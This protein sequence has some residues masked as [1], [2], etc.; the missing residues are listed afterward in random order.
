MKPKVEKPY[1]VKPKEFY[2]E[3]VI[4]K[5][6]DALTPRAQEMMIKI[7]NK[8]SQRLVYK[9]PEDRKDCISSAYLDLLKYWRSFNP[10][11]GSNAFAY[12]TEIAKRGFAKGW[13]Q[14][15]PKKYKGTISMDS[16]GDDSEGIYSI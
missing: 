1:Y 11:K 14:I 16:H 15:H 13:N 6:Q 10:E 12:F 7:A 3:I 5:K 2:D 9:N 8:A 4:S